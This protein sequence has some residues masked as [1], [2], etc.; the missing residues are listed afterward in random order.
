MAHL[1]LG[2]TA[3]SLE[4]AAKYIRDG[5]SIASEV[6]QSEYLSLKMGKQALAAREEDNPG[7]VAPGGEEM[8]DDAK[9]MAVFEAAYSGKEYK[10]GKK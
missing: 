10:G 9:A 7:A 4:T 8:E 3:G 2:E 1:K 6:V 5:S